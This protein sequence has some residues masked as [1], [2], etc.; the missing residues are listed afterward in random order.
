MVMLNAEPVAVQTDFGEPAIWLPSLKVS[1]LTAALG[2]VR[3]IDGQILDKDAN[4]H[5]LI[6]DP[7]GTI[8][9][10]VE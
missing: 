5:A 10:L 1:D 6:R 7:N 8:S 4:D 3:A 9:Y 2:D